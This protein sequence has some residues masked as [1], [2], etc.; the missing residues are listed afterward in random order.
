MNCSSSGSLELQSRI[1]EASIGDEASEISIEEGEASEIS[2]EE[3]E[4]SEIS[5]EEGDSGCN[6]DSVRL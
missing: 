4:A 1:S 2:I 5:I 6:G 3:G